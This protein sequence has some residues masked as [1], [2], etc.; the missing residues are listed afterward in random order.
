MSPPLSIFT[1]LQHA[2][3]RLTHVTDTARQNAETLLGFVL[4]CTRSHLHTWPERL[5]D[6]DQAHLYSTLIERHAAGEPV[7]Y[8]TGQREF[9]SMTLEV[10]RDTL[11]PRPETELLVELALQ[12]IPANSTWRILDLGTGSGA[13]AL[14]IARERPNC[15]VIA[16]DRSPATLAVARRNAATLG[17]P[18]IEFRAGDWFTPL[19]GETLHIII[20]NPPYVSTLDPRLTESDIRFE[21]L[22]ALASGADGLDDIRAIAEAACHHLITGGWLLLEH[23]YDQGT[24]VLQILHDYGY[25][26]VSNSQDLAGI[27]RV[28]SG[29]K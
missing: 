19:Q 8:L 16:T 4:H 7:A 26:D 20:S 17:I 12:R 3:Q 21:P 9:W 29:L 14:A 6:E 11:I 5:L 10:T 13:I 24:A 22:C 25:Q 27:D 28:V 15:H 18:N 2:T 23:G 1:A